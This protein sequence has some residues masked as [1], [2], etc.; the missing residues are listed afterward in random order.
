MKR[1][2]IGFALTVVT[3]HFGGAWVQAQTIYVDNTAKYSSGHYSW[4]V[5]LIA[6]DA[7]LKNIDYVEYTL[8]PSFPNPVQP[9]IR[10]RGGKC[11]FALTASSWGEF[12]VK[13]KVGLK[14]GS[15]VY[16]KH[17]LTLLENKN[18]AS[19]CDTA[20]APSPRAARKVVR[21]RGN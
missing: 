16:L 13:V 11:A 12:E 5:F 4:T 2:I 1:V 21:R 8:H 15:T 6:D 3:I 14:N 19:L 10:E 9:P 18:P 7:T 20:K 17:W